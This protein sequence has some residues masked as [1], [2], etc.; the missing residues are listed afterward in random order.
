M[1]FTKA[2][3]SQKGRSFTQT[4]STSSILRIVI[5]NV[6]LISS[7]FSAILMDKKLY[8]DQKFFNPARWLEP[9]YPTYKEPL[10]TYPNCQGF[11]S[12]GH[13]RRFCPGYD[14]AERTL[15]ILVARL[16]WACT[17]QKPINPITK[18]PNVIELKHE[19]T[20]APKPYPFPCDIVPR[21][22]ERV[23]LIQR[24]TEDLTARGVQ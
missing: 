16:A 2:T 11:A 20:P 10:E 4:I 17:I 1:T 23:K 24:E 8:P 3:F 13:G 12:F 19:P 18:K 6:M 22:V 14:L 7:G 21:Y 9:S 5:L 15:V